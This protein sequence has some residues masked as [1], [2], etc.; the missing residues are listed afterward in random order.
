MRPKKR[1]TRGARTHTHT[2]THKHTHTHTHTHTNTHTPTHYSFYRRLPGCVVMGINPTRRLFGRQ[3]KD[4][5]AASQYTLYGFRPRRS[6]FLSSL[7]LFFKFV[8]EE[9]TFQVRLY[10]LSRY[11]RHAGTIQITF[12]PWIL[13]GWLVPQKDDRFYVIAPFFTFAEEF[14]R[15]CL[16]E[17]F[18]TK[19]C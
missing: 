7:C 8:V 3:K 14:L 15:T 18:W 13:T 1:G 12:P 2:H 10:I 16:A 4:A 19:Y 6:H 17:T 11:L 5:W 9:I